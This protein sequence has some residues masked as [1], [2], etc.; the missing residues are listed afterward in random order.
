MSEVKRYVPVVVM[1]GTLPT[2]AVCEDGWLIHAVDHERIV[3]DLRAEVE[4][5]S[6]L[7]VDHERIVAGLRAEVERLRDLAGAMHSATHAAT[8]AAGMAADEREAFEAKFPMPSDCIRAGNSYA[9]TEF[10]AWQAQAYGEI[11]KGWIA[12]LE[13]RESSAPSAPIPPAQQPVEGFDKREPLELISRLV[14]G[15]EWALPELNMEPF[16]WGSGESADA[17]QAAIDAVAEAR[18]LLGGSA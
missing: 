7:A 11:R 18:A 10:N 5:L 1:G 4:L 2:V 8:H 3:A 16:E 12:A 6:D 17:H 14:A 9:A 15:L 13:W